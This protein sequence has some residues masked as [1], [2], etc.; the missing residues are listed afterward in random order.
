M[1]YVKNI[2]N[3][4]KPR[5]HQNPPSMGFYRKGREKTKKA[6]LPMVRIGARLINF[7]GKR[8]VSTKENASVQERL[9]A[10]VDCVSERGETPNAEITRGQGVDEVKNKLQENGHEKTGLGG[11]KSL[12]EK[13]GQAIVKIQWRVILWERGTE[14]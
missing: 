8:R 5:R 11:G 6:M 1:V 9:I 2:C 14:P 13:N 12:G 4:G 10:G 7:G 3:P